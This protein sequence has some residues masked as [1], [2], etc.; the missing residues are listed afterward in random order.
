VNLAAAPPIRYAAADPEQEAIER[1][2]RRLARNLLASLSDIDRQI[3]VRFYYRGQTP[4]DICRDLGL[5]ETQFR[6][7]KSRAKKRFEHLTRK[8]LRREKLFSEFSARREAPA[9]D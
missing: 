4:A 9:E 1:Q 6:L 2:R 3:L 7:R 5:N 8:L